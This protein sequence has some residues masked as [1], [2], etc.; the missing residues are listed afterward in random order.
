MKFRLALMAALAIGCPG[1]SEIDLSGPVAG[2]PEYGG[3]KGGGH[4]SP[5]TQIHRGNVAE[6]EVAWI[7][8]TGDYADGSTSLAPSSFENTPIVVDET[9]YLCT[10]FNRVIALDAESGTELW[11]FDPNVDTSQLYLQVCRGVTAWDDPRRK[12]G[13]SCARRIF[14]GTLDARL[15]ALDALTGQPCEDFGRKGEVDLTRDLGAVYP[16]EYGVSSPPVVVRGLVVTGSF[17]LDNRRFNAPAGIVRAYDVRTGQLRWDWNPIPAGEMPTQADRDTG[18]I[19]Y[20]KGTPN[21][22]SIMSVDPQRGLVFAPTGNTSP[23]YYGGDRHGFDYYSSSVVALHAASGQVIWR[24][25]TVNHDVWDYDVPS[26]PTLFEFPD[27]RRT[28]P[29]LVQATK[30]GHLFF[31]NREN[32][33]P[34][35]EV[36]ERPVPV[37]GVPGELL[38]MTQPFP[39]RPPPIHPGEPL[40][41]DDAWG[42]TFWDRG[43]CREQIAALRSE[44]IFTPPSLEGSIHYPGMGGGANWGSPAL[45]PERGIL[46]VNTTRVATHVR[47]VPRAEVTPEQAA[48]KYGFEPA[49]GSP[50]ALERSPLLSPF[51]APCNPPPWGTLVGVDIA[52][53]E[54]LWDVPLGTTR[55]MA[56]FPLWFSLGVP[57]Q[58]GPMVTG[59]GLVFI[60]AA[61]D[62]FLRAFDIET[63]EELWKARLPAGGQ[64]TPMTYRTRAGGKQFVVIAAGGHGIMGTTG[65]DAIVAFSLPD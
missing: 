51:G 57:N 11:T 35:F 63:G 64:A 36:V 61:S 1:A 25:K 62:N 20:R 10:P 41:P 38:A 30:M 32:G 3:A 24:F 16:G 4:Y 5:L 54:I 65:G 59:S 29:A 44:G 21:V 6:L 45:D 56:P 33:I 12:A 17:V 40:T 37:G 27:G 42:F 50:Y 46:V 2:W 34:I 15:I 7:Y 22:W 60:A 49:L 39:T 48:A 14:M 13:Q 55:D 28:I 31:L 8:H 23:D 53:G 47:L 19:V 18:A 26:Q 52:R 9:L 43:K 58:G